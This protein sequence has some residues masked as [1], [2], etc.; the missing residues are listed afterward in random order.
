M[1]KFYGNQGPYGF[2]SNFHVAIF[3]LN[4]HNWPSVEHAYQAAKSTDL[5]VQ[6]TIRCLE[7]PGD[8]KQMGKTIERRVDWEEVVGTPALHAMFSDRQGVVVELVK[9]HFMFQALTAKF[10]QRRELRAALLLTGESDLVENSPKDHYWG[11][12]KNGTGQ[13]K[14]GRML[15]LVR[16]QLQATSEQD[17]TPR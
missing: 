5:E 11:I 17:A 7:T 12:G 8:T 15:Q 14:L 16:S 1:I 13:N 10:R 2:L 6:R 9:D 4:G 3:Q